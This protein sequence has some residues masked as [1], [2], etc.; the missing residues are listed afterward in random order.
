MLVRFDFTRR[1]RASLNADFSFNVQLSYFSRTSSVS[2][3]SNA[4]NE[5]RPTYDRAEYV[6]AS[7]DRRSNIAIPRF[8]P[9]DGWRTKTMS[10]RRC[11]RTRCRRKC[12]NGWRRL[13]PGSSQPRDGR[14]TRSRNSARSRTPSGLAYS[15]I[16]STG[17]SRIPPS[18]NF[19]RR[20]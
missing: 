6:S 5:G 11:S 13:S 19:R 1:C 8:P 14:L 7:A 18:C 17:G 15:S 3:R 10:C 12:A 2:A 16:G 9:L 20:S 4:S